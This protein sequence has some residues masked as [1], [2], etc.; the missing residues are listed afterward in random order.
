M[1]ESRCGA[2]ASSSGHTEEGTLSAAEQRLAARIAHR[3]VNGLLRSTPSDPHAWQCDIN[4]VIAAKVTRRAAE[5][6]GLI[7]RG[8][9]ASREVILVRVVGVFTHMGFDGGPGITGTP[10]PGGG[11]VVNIAVDPDRQRKCWDSGSPFE[12]PALH[13]PNVIYRK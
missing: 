8:E 1:S 10:V 11:A 4:S 2:P 5:T 13:N 9:C 3:E 6:S 7:N 12:L